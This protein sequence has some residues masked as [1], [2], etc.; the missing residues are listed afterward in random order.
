LIKKEGR[1]K[2]YAWCGGFSREGGVRDEENERELEEENN[3]DKKRRKGEVVK[4]L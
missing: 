1:I 3:G 2:K 4:I